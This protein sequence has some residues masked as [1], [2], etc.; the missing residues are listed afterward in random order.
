MSPFVRQFLF[1]I[2]ASQPANAQGFRLTHE[3]VNLEVAVLLDR[4]QLCITA[5]NKT[6]ISGQFGI[7]IDAS[8]NNKAAWRDKLPE[9]FAIEESYFKLPLAIDLKTK[10]NASGQTLH[11]KLGACSETCKLL[12]FDFNLPRVSPIAAS[13]LNCEHL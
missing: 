3:G 11:I 2:L 9:R 5:D 13:N 1:A 12:N 4:V 7:S 6:K 10:A 8:G